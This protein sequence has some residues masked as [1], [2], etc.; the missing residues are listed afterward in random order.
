VTVL[1]ADRCTACGACLLTCPEAALSAAPLRP[2]VDDAACTDCL[3]C[4]EVCP[5]DAIVPHPIEVESYRRMAELVDLSGWP[6]GARQVVARMV[7]ATADESFA[8]T[9]RVGPRAV[10]AAVAALR[11]GATVVCD[12]N[13]VMAGARSVPTTVC[14]LSETGPAPAGT[15]RSADAFRLAA[16]RYPEGALWVVGNAPTALDALLD[17]HAGGHVVPAA[18]IGLPVGYVGAAEA[19]QRL[20]SGPLADVSVTNSGRRGGSPVAAAAL[21]ALNALARLA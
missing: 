15:T 4:L 17:L 9:A 2:A 18:V 8:T 21:N 16:A 13:M 3:A 10:E 11:A 20:W 6:D 19:K 14:L 1:V 12:S 5:V 7:H